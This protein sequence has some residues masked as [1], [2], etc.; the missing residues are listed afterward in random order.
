MES[1]SLLRTLSP[2]SVQVVVADPP[3]GVA[4]HSNWYSG[5]NPHSPVAR[6][7]NFQVGPFLNS[8]SGVLCD[9][10]VLYLFTRWDVFPL[11]AASIPPSLALKNVIVWV[12]DNHSSGDLVGN[13]GNKYELIMMLCKGEAPS[14]GLPMVERLGVP[15]GP[16]Q[17]T[18]VFYTETGRDGGEAVGVLQ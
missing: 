17:E 9:G 5:K 12:K 10:G 8:V 1:N 13:F 16:P 18:S 6:D 4:Y 2:G 14:S 7:W 15:A 3:Y 11:W